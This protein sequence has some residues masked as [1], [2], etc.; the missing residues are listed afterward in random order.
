MCFFFAFFSTKN[1]FLEAFYTMGH[2]ACFLFAKVLGHNFT[3]EQIRDMIA[4]VDTTKSGD[5]TYPE[6]CKALR[7]R[8]SFGKAIHMPLMPVDAFTNLGREDKRLPSLFQ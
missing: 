3:D 1:R 6:F 8:P 4:N 7:R 5:V 2:T